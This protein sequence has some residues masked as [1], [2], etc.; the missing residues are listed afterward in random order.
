[1]QGYR[2]NRVTGENKV[3]ILESD[4]MSTFIRGLGPLLFSK[5]SNECEIN[6][7]QMSLS[8]WLWEI[9]RHY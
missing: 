3:E 2:E 4:L 1:M 9:L 7:F 5:Q 8:V 6:I